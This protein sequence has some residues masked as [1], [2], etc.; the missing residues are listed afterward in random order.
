MVSARPLGASETTG[1][2]TVLVCSVTRKELLLAE[3]PGERAVYVRTCSPDLFLKSWC[4]KRSL[5][6][7]YRGY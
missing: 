2:A 7:K 5:T 4:R 1:H 3:W 6:I